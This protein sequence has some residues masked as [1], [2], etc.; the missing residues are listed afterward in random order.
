MNDRTHL[1]KARLALML[2]LLTALLSAVLFQ[3]AAPVAAACGGTTTVTDEASLDAAIVAFNAETGSCVFTIEFDN[4]ITLDNSLTV[5]D[6]SDPDVSLIINGASY[7]LSATDLDSMNGLTIIEGIV[8]VNALTITRMSTGIYAALDV[9]SLTVNESTFSGNFIGIVSDAAGGSVRDSLFANNFQFGI[10]VAQGFVTLT[11]STFS[12]NADVGVLVNTFGSALLTNITSVNNGQAAVNFG[13][14]TI[15]NS[16]LAGSDDEDCFNVNTVTINHTLIEDTDGEACG[17]TAANP[18]A[19]GNIVG[20]MAILGA[21][22]NYGGPTQTIPLL[23]LSG[24]VTAA[25][26]AIDAGDNALAVDENSAPLVF[27]QRGSGFP[28]ILNGTVDMGAYE[29]ASVVVCPAFPATVLDETELNTAILCYNYT[30]TPG[31]YTITLDADIDLTASTIT[32]DNDDPTIS[33]VIEGDNRTVDGQDI[34]GVRPL[35]IAAETT[36]TLNDATL[37]G[38]NV[39]RDL[40]DTGDGGA[41]LNGGILTINNVTLTANTARD[42][43]GGGLASLS[44]STTTINDS[45]ISNNTAG[46][47]GVNESPGDGGGIRNEGTMIIRRSLIDNNSALGTEGVYGGGIYNRGVLRVE[48]STISNNTVNAS[49]F[50]NAGGGIHSESE[51]VIIGSAIVNNSV[52]SGAA[53]SFL[54]SSGGGINYANNFNDGQN[55]IYLINSTVSGNSVTAPDEVYGGG[56]YFNAAQT[57]FGEAVITNSTISNNSVTANGRLQRGGRRRSVLRGAAI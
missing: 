50:G 20:E 23:T 39:T 46:Q 44:G 29:G 47:L 48:D 37:T 54:P 31:V 33:L 5:I 10:V 21:L 3:T 57:P 36:V 40:N 24:S 2:M 16:I 9:D 41:I 30:T 34:V 14:I 13:S 1:P 26:P 25:S 4:D 55:F 52:T 45:T 15:N 42:D 32:V 12:N 51:T 8:T 49:D 28:R 53:E 19:D 27:D 38:G 7:T 11:N 17:L 6:N 43:D 18:D 56:F 22:G 35:T